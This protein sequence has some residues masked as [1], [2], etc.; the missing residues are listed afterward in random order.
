MDMTRLEVERMTLDEI[1][2][3]LLDGFRAG[4][5]DMDLKGVV[6]GFASAMKR[7]RGPSQRQIEL[8]RRLVVELRSM[9]P[10]EP[11]NLIDAGDR[12]E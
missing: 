2:Q 8:A 10:D 4:K 12:D 9:T 3:R 7:P 5:L 11:E 6:L 1:R